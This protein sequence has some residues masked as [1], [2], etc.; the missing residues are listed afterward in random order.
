MITR[1]RVLIVDDDRALLE[2]LSDALELRMRSLSVETTDSAPDALARLRESDYDAIVADIKMPGMDGIELLGRIRELRPDTPT[3]LITGHGE[4]DLAI[5][6]IR[7]GAQDY[8]QKPIDRD[9]FVGS[10]RHAIERRRLSRKVA[11]NKQR[12]EKHTRDL[13]K[14]LEDRSRELRELY[15]REAVARAELERTSAE[16]EAAERRRD[17]LVSVIAHELATPLTT[18]RGY[19]TILTRPNVEP[20]TRERAKSIML[21]ETGRMHRLV[22]DLVGDSRAGP[23]R[24]ALRVERCDL[25]TVAREQVELASARSTRHTLRLDSPKRLEVD[26]DRERVAQVFANLLTNAVTYTNK[27]EIRMDLWREGADAHVRVCDEGPGI[28]TDSL[29]TIFQPRVRLDA[30]QRRSS[31][32]GKGLGLSI[33]REIVEAH[34]GRIW[35]ESEPGRGASF[36]VVLPLS[37]AR[38]RRSR[39]GNRVGVTKLVAETPSSRKSNARRRG[40]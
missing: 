30:P 34:G 40:H 8:I 29:D 22:Q 35:A 21:S 32:N 37:A 9:Y 2:A 26:C 20:A 38:V 11:Q 36:N 10:L 16:L 19:A 25:A 7:G 12:L 33:A 15:E 4:H 6:A 1:A 13:E 24:L 17:D 14:C 18:L 39:A 23:D 3:L 5:E 28:P 31:A 27:G